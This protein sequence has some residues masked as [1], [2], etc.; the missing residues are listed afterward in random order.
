MQVILLCQTLLLATSHS[1]NLL[2]YCL[3]NPRFRKRLYM[4]L[5][6]RQANESSQSNTPTF[7]L[8]TIP[9]RVGY[10]RPIIPSRDMHQINR[11]TSCSLPS[12]LRHSQ[13]DRLNTTNP[14]GRHSLK[15]T[16]SKSTQSSQLNVE[17]S[18][19]TFGSII[20]CTTA[21]SCEKSLKGRS[22]SI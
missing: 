19:L 11:N 7:A 9:Q 18:E 13:D 8:Q 16:S 10:R 6:H 2:I 22:N 14:Q 21:V 15:K 20:T 12:K 5:L 3:S 17:Y 4:K 1:C